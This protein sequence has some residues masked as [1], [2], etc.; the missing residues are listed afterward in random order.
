[1]KWLYRSGELASG[2]WDLVV[3]ES[4]PNWQHT[5]LRIGDFSKHRVFHI[6]A[7]DKER[8]IF[9]L[10]GEHLDVKYT[11]NGATKE[12]R[13]GGRET[14]FS[15]PTDLLYLPMHTEAELIG[16]GR[17]AIGEAKAVEPKE[18]RFISR[19][20]VPVFIRGAGRES[21]QVHNF[22]VPENLDA[23]RFI[24]VEVLVPSGNWSGVP[25][26]KHDTYIPGVESNLEEIYYFE[27][28]ATRG[29]HPASS[30]PS[31]YARGYASDDR[32]YDVAAEVS[33]GDV[34]LVPWGWHGPVAATPGSDLY[35]F[36]VMAGPD[37]DRSWNIT[38]D[39]NHAWIRETWRHQEPDSRLP[40]TE[41]N[42][43]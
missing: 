1:M 24:V 7:N 28:A 4:L 23:S 13:L 43:T 18:P 11:F 16:F 38:D 29:A 22:G 2:P 26:H 27:A 3:D 42:H 21:R 12:V 40:Y 34:L 8:I 19:N 37:P 39:P 41:G 30:A 20:E 5:G 15:G 25:A 14:V 32:L 17:V 33:S 31:G 35:F 9:L 36:N 6:P 10:E